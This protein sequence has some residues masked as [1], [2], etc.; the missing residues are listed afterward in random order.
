MTSS[1]RARGV[2]AGLVQFERRVAGLAFE[3]HSSNSESRL[4]MLAQ[5]LAMVRSALPA[6]AQLTRAVVEAIL[7]SEGS[8]GS[9][10]EVARHLGL[11][12]RFKLARMLREDGLPSLHRLAEWATVESWVLAAER[13]DVSLCYLAFRSRRHP[14][15]CYRLVKRITGICW[16][17]VRARGSHWVQRQI[18]NLLKRAPRN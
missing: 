3:A 8:I 13:D 15:A 5:S 18:Q 2:P 11:P 4:P 9:A 10:Q 14:S 7:L 17:D 6:M 1:Y 12:N 16:D